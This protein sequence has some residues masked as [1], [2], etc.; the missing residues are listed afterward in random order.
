VVYNLAFENSF[1]L[2][3]DFLYTPGP[4]SLI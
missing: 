3:V 2:R 1:P 4:L